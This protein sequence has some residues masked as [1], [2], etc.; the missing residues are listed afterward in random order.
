MAEI[1]AFYDVILPL[2]PAAMKHM[3][4]FAPDAMPPAEARLFELVLAL[5]L[6]SMASDLQGAPRAHTPYQH[7]VKMMKR[8]AHFACPEDLG[9]TTACSVFRV[10]QSTCH[11]L[12][13]PGR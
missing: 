8:T 3:E 5:A 4:G 7:G 6:V 1:T 11:L 9:R 2:A 10:P 12:E 13:G